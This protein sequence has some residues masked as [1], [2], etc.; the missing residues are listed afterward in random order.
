MESNNLD[1]FSKRLRIS[2]NMPRI[3]SINIQLLK[4]PYDFPGGSDSKASAYNVGDLGSI[5]GS[6]RSIPWRRKWQPTP[7]LLSGKSHGQ[8]SLVS[9]SP[10]GRKESDT[11]EWLK[12][13]GLNGNAFESVLM[14]WMNLEPIIQSEASQK[15]KDKY[16]ILMHINGI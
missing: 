15:E 2:V 12:T 4:I 9:Y 13:Y 16:R 8:R 10:W 5:P 3:L 7:V 1:I 6:G 11:T 14:R